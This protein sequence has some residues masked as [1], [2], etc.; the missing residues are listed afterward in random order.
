MPPSGDN[1][2]TQNDDEDFDADDTPMTQLRY[3][4][5]NYI[6]KKQLYIDFIL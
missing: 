1:N 3:S 2:G 5:S 6:N 4:S